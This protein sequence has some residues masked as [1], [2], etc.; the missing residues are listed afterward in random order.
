[1]TSTRFKTYIALEFDNTKLDSDKGRQIIQDINDTCETIRVAFEANSC[2][3]DKYI[4]E[5]SEYFST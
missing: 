2:Y 3:L 1:M 5:K 4:E